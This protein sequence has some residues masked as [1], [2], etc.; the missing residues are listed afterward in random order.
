MVGTEMKRKVEFDLE[1]REARFKEKYQD[2]FE[3]LGIEPDD[4][5]LKEWIIDFDDYSG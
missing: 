2:F 4:F 1:E 3:Y 5:D